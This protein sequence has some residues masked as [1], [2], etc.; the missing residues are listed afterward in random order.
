M[1]VGDYVKVPEGLT[2]DPFNKRGQIGVVAAIHGLDV[3]VE[4][5]DLNYILSVGKYDIDALEPS[6]EKA[7]KKWFKIAKKKL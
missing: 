2:T 5:K 3:T 1:R 7:Y 6:T 4:F